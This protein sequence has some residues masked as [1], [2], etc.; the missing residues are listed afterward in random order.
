MM[1][2]I[3]KKVNKKTFDKKLINNINSMPERDSP[4]YLLDIRKLKQEL[5]TFKNAF[6]KNV[7][8]CYSYKTNYLKPIIQTFDNLGVLSEIVSSFEADLTK[9]FGIN[10]RKVIYNGPIKSS[11]SIK[12]IL[13]GGGIVNADSLDDLKKICE[14]ASVCKNKDSCK[15]GIRLSFNQ[16]GLYSR[17]GI[18]YSSETHKKILSIISDFSIPKIS[19]IHIHMPNRDLNSF[20][21]RA[22]AICSLVDNLR[23]EKD[24]FFDKDLIIDLG[25]G[26][27]SNMNNEVKKFLNGSE[28]IKNIKEYGIELKKLQTK[29]KLKNFKFFLEPGTALVSNSLLLVGNIHNINKK[30]QSTFINTDISRTHLGGLNNQVPYPITLIDNK[31]NQ[32]EVLLIEGEN[33]ISGFTC[34]ESDFLTSKLKDKVKI[35]KKDKFLISDVGSY[36]TVFKSPFIQADIELYVWDGK[37]LILS[38]RA[39]NAK[40]ICNLYLK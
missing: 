3:M 10:P 34:V 25:G 15:I 7:H 5:N 11:N 4:F 38:R 12:Y 35:K 18:E 21:L 19:C 24:R 29:Y 23:L 39:Q 16:K 2:Q 9:E 14:I 13:E 33:T 1:Y 37:E 22:E 31:S 36:S 17:F 26:F 30:K 6:E 32:R 8:V 20:I 40:D 27:P 28:S